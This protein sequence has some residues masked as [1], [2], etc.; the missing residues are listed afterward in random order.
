MVAAANPSWSLI[1]GKLDQLDVSPTDII[2]GVNRHDH[3]YMRNG[4]GWHRVGGL[5]THVTVGSAGVWGR[6][7]HGNIYYRE[8]VTLSNP[9]GTSWTQIPGKSRDI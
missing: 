4:N 7:V 5:L 8:G 6:N 3:I 1:P 9:A 2:W